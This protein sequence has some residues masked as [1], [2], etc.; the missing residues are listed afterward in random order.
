M[1]QAKQRGTFS[2][3]KAGAV[4]HRNK[5]Y[6]ER[7]AKLDAE[8]DRQMI[9]RHKRAASQAVEN[10]ADRHAYFGKEYQRGAS[11]MALAAIIGAAIYGPRTF[12]IPR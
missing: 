4:E 10:E 2:E 6:A 8:A 7:C 11:F 1:G 9:E 5:E 3:R 12:R